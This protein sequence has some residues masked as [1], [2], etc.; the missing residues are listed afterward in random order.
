MKKSTFDNLMI[1][2]V[3]IIL[4]VVS[5]LEKEE[6]SYIGLIPLILLFLSGKVFYK[7]S[8]EQEVPIRPYV[9]RLLEIGYDKKKLP[10]S[11]KKKRLTTMNNPNCG[12]PLEN[13][14]F[15]YPYKTVFN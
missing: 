4:L 5:F 2:A 14:I 13:D 8:Q 7:K 12:I 15:D 3:A 1:F 10:A 9:F 6:Y 11:D